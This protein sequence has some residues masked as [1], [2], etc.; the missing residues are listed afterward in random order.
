MRT[1]H[2]IWKVLRY[3]LDLVAMVPRL[4]WEGANV[5]SAAIGL[6]LS[7]F[8]LLNQD[9]ASQWHVPTWTWPIPVIALVGWKMLEANY[10]KYAGERERANL[11]AEKLRLLT[12]SLK[13]ALVVESV[14]CNFFIPPDSADR[15]IKVGVV[16]TNHS[17]VP[18]RYQRRDMQVVLGGRTV[19]NPAFNN[20]GGIVTANGGKTVHWFPD[21]TIP[22]AEHISGSLKLRFAYGPALGEPQWETDYEAGL[23]LGAVRQMEQPM[24]LWQVPASQ[25]TIRLGN[26]ESW[27]TTDPTPPSPR[28]AP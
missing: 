4:L 26:D 11:A 23:E 21:I 2:G 19:A 7:V 3:H 16:L 28:P 20:D 8:L 14:D 18:L 13:Y 22:V 12:E 5:V 6:V 1:L 25:Q 15:S 17:A 9:L 10:I 24:M 27:P